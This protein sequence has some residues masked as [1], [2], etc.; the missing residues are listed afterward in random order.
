MSKELVLNTESYGIEKSKAEQIEKTFVPMVAMLKEF[1]SAFEAITAEANKGITKEVTLKAKKIRLEIAKIRIETDKIR[2]RE[3]EEYLRAGKAIDG[4]ANI[5]KFAVS[6]KEEKLKEIEKHFENIEKERLQKIHNERMI[7]LEEYE[8]DVNGVDLG[9]MPDDVY[10]QFLKGY[11]LA[12]E[13]KKAAEKK[14]EEERIA[15]EEAERKRQI[16][17]EAEN[18]RLKAEAEKA[19]AE[20]AKREKQEKIEAEKREAERIE[21]EKKE[22]ELEKKRLEEKAKQEAI[23]EAERA[24]AE[25]KLQKE[26]AE[27]EKI[28][29]ELA[30]K[31]AEEKRIADEKAAAEK[32]ARLAPDKDKLLAFATTIQSLE[33]PLVT[34]KE[35][36]EIL[37]Q[38]RTRLE[39]TYSDL[40]EHAKKI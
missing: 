35:A 4:V 1:E 22:A 23:L 20:E 10:K 2:K 30:A 6:E 7:E 28:E 9:S 33:I 15:R 17:I 40:I 36:Q 29:R 11:K 3:K 25:K 31:K 16:E 13:N 19:K 8:A 27:K 26:K 39:K 32:K 38:V 21:R 5:L 37:Q 18:K 34:N 14:A 24:E 12:Y